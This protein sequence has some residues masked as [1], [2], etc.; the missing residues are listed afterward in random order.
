VPNNLLLTALALQLGCFAVLGVGLGGISPPKG[1]EGL[2]AG[3]VYFLPLYA[4]GIMAAGDVKFFAVL[5]LLLG[6]LT[7]LPVV[8]MGSLLAGIHAVLFCAVRAGM[9]P[10]LQIVA[11]QMARWQLYRR[12]LEKR[13]NRAGIPYAAYLACGA[14]LVIM[15][16]T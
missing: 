11:M 13:G 6:Q 1:L 9:L 5:G 12:I 16:A 3:L 4:L 7:L 10:A 8:L 15:R 2:A 14:V